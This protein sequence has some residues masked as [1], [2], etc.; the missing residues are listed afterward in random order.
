MKIIV[1]LGNPGQEYSATRHNAGFMVADELARRYHLSS[2]RTRY[3]GLV[4][5]Y[6]GEL[7]EFILMKPQTYMNLSGGSR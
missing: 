7:G 1:G 3:N 5:E 6:R 4:S 2:W